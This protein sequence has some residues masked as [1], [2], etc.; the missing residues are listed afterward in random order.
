[1]VC[2]YGNQNSNSFKIPGD[3]YCNSLFLFSLRYC[4]MCSTIL[5]EFSCIL[6]FPKVSFHFLQAPKVS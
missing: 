3:G 2:Q 1:M 4:I 5:K 6:V